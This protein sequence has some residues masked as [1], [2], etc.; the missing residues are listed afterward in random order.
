MNAD[1]VAYAAANRLRIMRGDVAR[2][3]AKTFDRA[4]KTVLRAYDNLGCSDEFQRLNFEPSEYVNEQGKPQRPVTMTKNGFVMLAVGF[5]GPS[6]MAFKKAFI[7]TFNVTADH[8]QKLWQMY[9]ALM[10]NRS[11][12]KV[13]ASSIALV[14]A[15]AWRPNAMPCMAPGVMRRWRRCASVARTAIR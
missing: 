5:T 9:Q 15:S 4:H 1:H 6:A 11:E 14:I 8:K 10:A 7:A 3:L 12:S 2:V 13:R